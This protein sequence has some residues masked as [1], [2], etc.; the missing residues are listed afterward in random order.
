[1]KCLPLFVLPL[2]L[3]AAGVALA[4]EV[5]DHGR[6]SVHD[7][8][9]EYDVVLDAVGNLDRGS[10]RRL[11]APDG[12]V[13]PQFAPLLDHDQIVLFDSGDGIATPTPLRLVQLAEYLPAP[14]YGKPSL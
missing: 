13:M 7:L 3:C 5:V 10:G 8:P 1:M 2:A 6:T 11:L 14:L 4:A 12:T 9:A